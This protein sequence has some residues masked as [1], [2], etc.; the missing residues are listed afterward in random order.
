MY[1]DKPI[2]AVSSVDAIIALSSQILISG[3]NSISLYTAKA[4]HAKPAKCNNWIITKSVTLAFRIP[5]NVDRNRQTQAD[6]IRKLGLIIFPEGGGVKT[7]I[8]SRSIPESNEKRAGGQLKK[9]KVIGVSGIAKTTSGVPTIIPNF[10]GRRNVKK[11]AMI[12]SIPVADLW[13]ELFIIHFF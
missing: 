1:C 12:P 8:P 10:I 7:T 13:K 6:A 9:N 3:R 4:K 5:G 11:T 2:K